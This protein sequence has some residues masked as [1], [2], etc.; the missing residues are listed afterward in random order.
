MLLVLAAIVLDIAV[1]S[2]VRQVLKWP[3][4][5]DSIGMILVGALLGPL[6]GAATG[7]LANLVWGALLGNASIAPYSITAAFIGWAAGYA[8][9]RGAFRHLWTAVLAGLLTGIGAAVISAPIT[10]FV[11]CWAA[12]GRYRQHVSTGLRSAGALARLCARERHRKHEYEVA[13]NPFSGQKLPG[14]GHA[15]LVYA[16]DPRADVPV[17]LQQHLVDAIDGSDDVIVS[18]WL[19]YSL[20]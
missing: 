9:S 7:A 20:T 10:A 19:R 5:L 4:F 6:A 3:L 15:P 14:A 12:P 1:G 18:G 2:F 16:R 11:Y 8:V 13:V 17:E